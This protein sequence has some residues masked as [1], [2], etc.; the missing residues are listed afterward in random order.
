MVAT[1]PSRWGYLWVEFERRGEY[2]VCGCGIKAN[3]QSERVTTWW[4]IT[5]KRPG[6]DISLVCRRC[7][8]V[9]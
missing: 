7:G 1:T 5:P 8:A 3:R 4:F 6:L 9:G 2:L